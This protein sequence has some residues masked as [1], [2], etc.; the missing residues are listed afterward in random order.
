MYG[1]QDM[2]QM[3]TGRIRTCGVQYCLYGTH[4]GVPPGS[5]FLI[6]YT[7]WNSSTMT[8]RHKRGLKKNQTSPLVDGDCVKRLKVKA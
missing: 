6:V 8:G 5:S 3:T 4:F 1:R 7:S 2:Q